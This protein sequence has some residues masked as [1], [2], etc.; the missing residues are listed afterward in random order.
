M[1]YNF[2]KQI[3]TGI[4]KGTKQESQNWLGVSLHFKNKINKLKWNFQ[5]EESKIPLYYQIVAFQEDNLAIVT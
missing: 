1:A 4:G 3:G 2:W 5:K